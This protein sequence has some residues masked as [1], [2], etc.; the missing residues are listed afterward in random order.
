MDSV[1]CV[2]AHGPVSQNHLKCCAARRQL[3]LLFSLLPPG[4]QPTATIEE[5]VAEQPAPLPQSLSRG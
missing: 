1:E 3:A 2:R 5:L 4:I